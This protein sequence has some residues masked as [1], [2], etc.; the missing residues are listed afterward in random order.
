M[1]LNI[2]RKKIE[3]VLELFN[4]PQ[5]RKNKKQP[6]K[7]KPHN[8]SF[9]RKKRGKNLANS[10]LKKKQRG[11]GF[12][13]EQINNMLDTIK[14]DTGLKKN[15]IKTYEADEKN[16][17]DTDIDIIE[18][19]NCD[20]FHHIVNL[21]K[22]ED[23]KNEIN[24]EIKNN[25]DL[26]KIIYEYI[27]K[28]IITAFP[29]ISVENRKKNNEEL[30]KHLNNLFVPKNTE[31]IN[32]INK[33]PDM[34][35]IKKEINYLIYYLMCNKHI[36]FDA[37][38]SIIF[39]NY[40]IQYILK[41]Y[42]VD[43]TIRVN[44][45][46]NF[47]TIDDNIYTDYLEK[48]NNRIEKFKKLFAFLK[49]I[50][51]SSSKI[52]PYFFV[53]LINKLINEKII[54]IDD[55][56]EI[57]N[58]EEGGIEKKIQDKIK[59]YITDENINSLTNLFNSGGFLTK[60]YV[61]NLGVKQEN[62]LNSDDD[63]NTEKDKNHEEFKKII[64][65]LKD[66][67][68]SFK[69]YTKDIIPK[70]DL[71]DDDK[72]KQIASLLTYLQNKIIITIDNDELIINDNGQEKL[73]DLKFSISEEGFLKEED[74]F[75]LFLY[76]KTDDYKNTL[77]YVSNYLDLT[78]MFPVKE[79]VEGEDSAKKV[80][81]E[82]PGEVPAS[83]SASVKPPGKGTGTFKE[84]DSGKDKS[85]DKFD[86]KK[87]LKL[88]LAS[89]SFTQYAILKGMLDINDKNNSVLEFIKDDNIQKLYSEFC[90][91]YF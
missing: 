13:D 41:S 25:E 89:S 53:N 2:T 9:N 38:L 51:N 17:K 88:S 29:E 90:D 39:E 79:S 45:D 80:P 14:Q 54:T 47:I 10:T 85:P 86:T 1:T 69:N 50:T 91:K 73:K 56:G 82:V 75:I 3:K 78:I 52:Q 60:M 67:H 61:E 4:H 46:Y 71:K 64:E 63:D 81:G 57:N 20:I 74:E 55:Y 72:K 34:L 16:S 77:N 32:L 23:F 40:N 12:T 76:E 49:R 68:S 65:M 70:Q 48:F 27:K 22:V 8:K 59:D 21:I 83:V 19:I 5:T 44:D 62:P 24:N 28:N 6:G 35:A 7:K 31:F 30:K 42:R 84:S 33:Q 37:S 15:I 87:L 11:G 43:K 36:T 58:Y 26:K 66:N 18:Q